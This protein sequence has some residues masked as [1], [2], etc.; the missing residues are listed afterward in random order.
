MKISTQLEELRLRLEEWATPL[1]GVASA[2][3]NLRE[4][5]NQASLST[6]KPRVMVCYMGERIRGPFADAA[7]AGMVDRTWN[8]AI[9]R[10]RGFSSSR[11]ES[12]TKTVGNMDPFP[13]SVEAVRDIIRNVE[14]IS[15]EQPID[16]KGI[17]PI[18][19]GNLVIDGYLIEFTTANILPTLTTKGS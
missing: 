16:F 13:D 7:I 18:Q 6:Q 10:G 4:L 11:G 14:G 2:V 19:L 1:G 17:K 8:V 15:Q 5:W 3:S 12:L 9:T